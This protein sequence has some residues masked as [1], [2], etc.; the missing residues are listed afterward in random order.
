MLLTSRKNVAFQ[1]SPTN[2][3]L[4][5]HPKGA[6]HHNTRW[7]PHSTHLGFQTMVGWT[8][9]TEGIRPGHVWRSGSCM[10]RRSWNY[11]MSHDWNYESFWDTINNVSEHFNWISVPLQYPAC[12][13][14]RVA[15]SVNAKHGMS[16]TM[17]LFEA[18]GK[19]PASIAI[20]LK[21]KKGVKTSGE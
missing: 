20:W 17:R 7:A 5:D 4:V 18:I 10:G 6:N 8:K 2:A 21:T 12:K 9:T 13:A 3:N 14:T 16:L 19:I 1:I 11:S 15:S